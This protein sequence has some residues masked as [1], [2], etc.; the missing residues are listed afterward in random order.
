[1]RMLR[2]RALAMLTILAIAGTLTSCGRYG[3]P[4]RPLP[5]PAAPLEAAAPAEAAAPIEAKAPAEAASPA[6][7]TGASTPTDAEADSAQGGS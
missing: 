5:T 7:A 1:M 2:R 6:E 4:V 3:R